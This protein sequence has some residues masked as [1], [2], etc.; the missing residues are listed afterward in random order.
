M[1]SSSAV[2][3]YC[4]SHDDSQEVQLGA[5]SVNAQVP[6]TTAHSPEGEGGVV[7]PE[8]VQ[9]VRCLREDWYWPSDVQRSWLQE[10]QDLGRGEI[11]SPTLYLGSQW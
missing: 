11:L 3:R 4:R 9:G 8:P 7:P 10:L 2:Q 5:L 1:R 6:F